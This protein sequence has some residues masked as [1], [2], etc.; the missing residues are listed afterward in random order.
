MLVLANV[1]ANRSARSMRWV[2]AVRV[3][4]IIAASG[5]A[6]VALQDL[7]PSIRPL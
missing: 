3:A 7:F 5:M 2:D 1:E 6:L 4:G